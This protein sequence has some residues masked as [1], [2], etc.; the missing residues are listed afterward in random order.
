[1]KNNEKSIKINYI[2]NLTYQ[3]L[4]I[5]T[6]LITAPYLSRVLKADGIGEYS[7]TGSL[8]AYF[9]MVAALGT[10]NYGNREISYLQNDRKKRTKVFWE[11]ELLSM[12]SVAVVLCAYFVF[13]IF[14]KEHRTLLLIQSLCLISVAMD[15][16]WL[17]QGLEEFGKVIGRNIF[18]KVVN[19]AFI[20]IAIKS[21]ED[22]LLYVLGMCVME[23]LSNMSIWLYVPKF[24][25]RPVLRELFAFE[26]YMFAICSNYCNDYIYDDG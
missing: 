18:F 6:P 10:L 13:L 25:D 4:S 8:V 11:I 5:I 21:K 12:A 2:Y 7:Y 15:I 19:I 26:G 9:I 14:Y 3:I 23:L 17:L 24:V 22:L 20:F 16:A 1:M